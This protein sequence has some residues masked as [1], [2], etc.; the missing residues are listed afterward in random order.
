MLGWLILVLLA[1]LG[2]FFL[3]G[4]DGAALFGSPDH[5][6]YLVAAAVVLGVYA[7]WIL[8]SYRDRMGQALL[9]LMTWLGLGLALVAGYS[10]RD[11][12]KILASRV[13]GELLPPGQA[14]L[15]EAGPAGKSAVRIRGRGD[16]H[17]VARAEINGAGTALLVDTGASAVVLTPRDAR[18]A[19]I[20]VNRLSY[21]VAVSTANGVTF[22]APV[23]L[24]SVSIGAIVVHDVDA[25]VAKAGGLQ[26]NLLGMSFL[27]RLGSYE[28]SRNFLTLRS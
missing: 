15:V 2:V 12:F 28:F 22:A 20:D 7:L 8:G 11:E 24:R 25:L 10:Y 3:A 21:T 17:F 6:I 26:E 16:G 19:G 13:A 4:G 9:Y 23:R 5:T 27:K 18:R 1:L 14:I